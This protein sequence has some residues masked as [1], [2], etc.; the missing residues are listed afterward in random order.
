MADILNLKKIFSLMIFVS[1]LIWF[2]IFSGLGWIIY[3]ISSP[4][5]CLS[6]SGLC[7]LYFLWVWFILRKGF[8]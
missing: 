4:W 6:Y 2:T 3:I 1:L 8:K 5:Y 7:F